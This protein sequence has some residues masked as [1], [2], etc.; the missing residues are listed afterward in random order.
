M[1]YRNVSIKVA[2]EHVHPQGPSL[3][4]LFSEV[5][6]FLLGLEVLVARPVVLLTIT[7]L[8]VVLEPPGAAAAGRVR[9]LHLLQVLQTLLHERLV[10]RSP[11]TPRHT[12]GMDRAADSQRRLWQWD[13]WYNLGKHNDIQT[14]INAQV[15]NLTLLRPVPKL[16][17][18]VIE[19][20]KLSSSNTNKRLTPQNKHLYKHSVTVHTARLLSAPVATFHVDHAHIPG[21]LC[22]A[23]QTAYLGIIPQ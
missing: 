2:Y 3:T 23:P 9:L 5:A 4:F 20:A 16:D 14:L 18:T 11:G 12:T 7:A 17:K 22:H 13:A 10:L 8:L 19:K 6:L 15:Y 1:K 21:A